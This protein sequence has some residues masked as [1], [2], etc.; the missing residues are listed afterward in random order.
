VKR[1]RV[2]LLLAG[3]TAALTLSACG[4]APTGVI[5]AGEPATGM[6]P[7]TGVFFVS[8]GTLVGVPRSTAGG[9]DAATAVRLVFAGP[10]GSESPYLTTELP[11]LRTG[12]D[13]RTSGRSV[14][15]SLP[16]GVA[17]LSRLAVRQLVCTAGAAVRA[18]RPAV[19]PPDKQ[20]AG[21]SVP[22]VRQADPGS[23]KVR[24]AGAGWDAVQ[25]DDGCPPL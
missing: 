19:G 14:V 6:D 20:S 10:V 15:I 2:P 17:P 12:P 9:M 22:F 5:Q 16:E 18:G 25:L 8:G 23:V 1:V 21:S 3:L 11:R 13:V 4:V 7:G 24:V